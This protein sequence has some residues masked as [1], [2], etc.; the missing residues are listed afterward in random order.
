M[1]GTLPLQELFNNRIF[2]VPDY[3]RGYA[4]EKRQV[5]EFLDDLALL[6]SSRRHYTGTVIFYKWPEPLRR[7]E[8]E[9]TSYVEVDV[10]DGQQ[11]LTTVVLML[12]EV[13]KALRAYPNKAKLA[14]GIRK[15]YVETK[16]IGDQ[17]LYKLSL[18]NDI[19]HFFK[20]AI[21]P[22]TP[23]PSV[24]QVAP[25]RRLR[26]ATQ[27]IA[28]YLETTAENKADP[29]EW[30]QELHDKLT[31]RLHF[32]L[33]EVEEEAEVGIIFE[34]TNDRGKQLTNLEKVKNYLLYAAS[35]LN[36]DSVDLH[37]RT[38]FVGLVNDAW[39]DILRQL[40]AAE[41]G[42]PENENQLLRADWLMRYDPQ[43]KNYE[44]SKSIRGRFDLRRGQHTQLLNDLREY[45]EG[46]RASCILYCDALKPNRNPAFDSYSRQ[47]ETRREVI[48]WNEKLV[49]IGTTAPFLPLLMAVRMCWPSESE[50]YLE[51]LKLC[52][53]FSFRVYRVA[54]VYSNRGQ[55]GMFRLAHEVACRHMNLDDT[56]REIKQFYG[57]RDLTRRFNEFTNAEAPQ[58]L[59]GWRGLHYFLYEYEGHL[60]SKQG[61]PPRFSWSD[62]DIK[63]E[64]IE[65]VLPQ[66]IEGRPYWQV[67]FDVDTHQEYKDDIGNL[68]L[69][70]DNSWYGNKPFPEKRGAMD[71][72]GR[73]YAK[74]LLLQERELVDWDDWTESSINER[75]AKLLKW[76]EKRWHIDFDDIS[77]DANVAGLD[78]A[79]DGGEEDEE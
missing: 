38:V 43:S 39:A 16:D 48:L 33:C 20:S 77:G 51:I 66:T 9:G 25:E 26:E 32:N 3:Q 68:T 18:N 37:N 73:C 15:K 28:N 57:A 11:R 10:V 45:V 44:G 6:D 53:A 22:V 30:L 1:N 21:L 50:K 42:S 49:R 8:D 12:N 4:W 5:Q 36:V 76:A 35:S 23:T 63:D 27:Q 74:S 72:D 46:L 14:Q 17:P 55:A 56:V 24:P 54:G 60:A 52:E 65:H 19:D 7:T 70:Q 29:G 41:L 58:N 61:V 67:R 13:S 59:Y 79:E 47:I 62:I 2:R 75:R 31:T 71:A 40:M 69:T 78:D 64:T 34:V